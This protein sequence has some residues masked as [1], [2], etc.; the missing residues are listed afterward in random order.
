VPVAEPSA[1][2]A[3][4]N[5]QVRLTAWVDGYVQGVGFRW[6]TRSHARRLGLLGTVANLPD[7][8]VEVIAEGARPVC[9]ELLSLIGG[10]DTPG[11]VTGVDHQ[12]GQAQ[13]KF[14][15]FSAL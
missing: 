3:G 14:A 15:G 10:P 12:W 13:G 8:R 9:A 2:G 7:G 1:D 11:R 4:R 6:W 5:G